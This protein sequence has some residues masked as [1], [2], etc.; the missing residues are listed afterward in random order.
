MVTD[1]YGTGVPHSRVNKTHLK[2]VQDSKGH[3]RTELL[4]AHLFPKSEFFS[5]LCVTGE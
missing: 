5:Q 2:V 3:R 4:G 1:D